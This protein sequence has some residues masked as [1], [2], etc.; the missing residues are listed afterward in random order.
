MAAA[1]P[2]VLTDGVLN[3]LGHEA[4]SFRVSGKGRCRWR[5]RPFARALERFVLVEFFMVRADGL[6]LTVMTAVRC[7][8]QQLQAL[9][10]IA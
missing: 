1:I 8:L 10:Q 2:S 7:C 4:D 9:P 6:A 5:L 3:Q